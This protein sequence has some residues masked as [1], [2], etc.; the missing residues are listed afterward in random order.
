MNNT[1]SG[2][3]SLSNFSSETVNNIRDNNINISDEQRISEIAQGKIF[4]LLGTSSAG[5]SSIITA[6][7]QIDQSWVEIGPDLACFSHLA[8]EIKKAFSEDYE[9]NVKGLG[10]H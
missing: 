6:L 4:V 9:K 1:I 7:R 3:N 5:K 8:D 2:A 10:S